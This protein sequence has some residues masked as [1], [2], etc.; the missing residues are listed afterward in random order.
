MNHFYL[1]YLLGVINY[2][3][4]PS[5]ASFISSKP[6]TLFKVVLHLVVPNVVLL[7]ISIYGKTGILLTV[8]SVHVMVFF[9]RIICTLLT[10]NVNVLLNYYFFSAKQ[11]ALLGECM[12]R[13]RDAKITSASFRGSRFVLGIFLLHYINYEINQYTYVILYDEKWPELTFYIVYYFIEMVTVMHALFYDSV[14]D[15]VRR[16]VQLDC[17]ELRNCIEH[18][19]LQNDTCWWRITHEFYDRLLALDRR[20]KDYCRTFQLQLVTIALN[21]FIS[22]FSIFYVN[23]NS[24]LVVTHNSWLEK[25]KRVTESLGFFTQLGALLLICRHS[26]YL[27]SEQRTLVRLIAEAQSMLTKCSTNMK[28]ANALNCRI[29]L[30]QNQMTIAPFDLFIF[31]MKY[32]LGIVAAIVT[33]LVVLLQFRAMEPSLN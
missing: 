5:K 21:T 25:Y 32:F 4:D 16:T 26:T 29:F 28:N 8:P 3:L 20:R 14:L 15:T 31:D 27:A 33:Y 18:N 22:S 12:D 23:L 17:V 13:F 1:F 2:R 24:I 11:T 7:S 10:M 19:R 30:L 9:I 6:I